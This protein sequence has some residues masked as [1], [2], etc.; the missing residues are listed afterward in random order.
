MADAHAKGY[1]GRVPS[2]N[3]IFKVFDRPETF[4]VLKS[5]VEQSA[6]PLKSLESH[7]SC[8][9]SGFSGSRFD[10]WF[11]HKWG[12]TSIKRAW[13][14]AHVMTGALTNVVT[15]VEIHGQWAADCVQMPDLLATTAKRFTINEVSGDLAYSSHS[16]LIAVTQVGGSP[17]IPF[18]KNATPAQG[19]LW[20]KMYHYVQLNR[21]A[22][23]KRYHLRSNVE[24]TFSMVKAKFGDGLRSKTD[25]AMK[26]E[27]LAKFVCHNLCC[28]IQSM[29]EFGIDPTFGTIGGQNSP[30]PTKSVGEA[31]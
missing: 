9:S 18:K 1:V 25:T 10:K 24:S 15:A 13:V 5:L 8:D 20:E 28:V 11:D 14:K 22:F 29:H 27:C 26:N 17:L 21:E 16:N 19:G 23:L 31:I 7:F 6:G 4:D 30:L 12:G 2:Y 3:M